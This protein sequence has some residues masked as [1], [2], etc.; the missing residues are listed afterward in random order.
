MNA[1]L[2]R[3]VYRGIIYT[4]DQLKNFTQKITAKAKEKVYRGVAYFEAAKQEKEQVKRE[5]VWRG[6]TY[7]G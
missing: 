2:K 6:N 7:M 3:R 4:E 5:L 1:K